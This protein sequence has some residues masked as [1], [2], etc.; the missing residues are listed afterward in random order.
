[1]AKYLP[2]PRREFRRHYLQWVRKNVRLVLG[3]ALGVIIS[4]V[5]ITVP[6]LVFTTTT[7][8]SYYFLGLLHAVILASYLFL[9]HAAFLAHDREA[10]WHLRGTWVRRT[11]AV[12]FSEPSANASSGAG[13]TASPFS[14]ATWIT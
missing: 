5:A 7:V 13:W 3:L 14:G 6:F 4:L 2:H 1:M 10:I 12:G 8:H 11:L 9:V